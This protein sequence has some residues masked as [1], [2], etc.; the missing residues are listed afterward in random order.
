MKVPV[1]RILHLKIGEI[2][3]LKI[4]ID[5]LGKIVSETVWTIH[6][7]KDK[8]NKFSGLEISTADSSRSIYMK[9]QIE[10]DKFLEFNSKHEKYE[11]GINLEK[12]NKMIKAVE[13][14]DIINMYLSEKD[15]QCLIIDIERAMTKGKKTLK[16]PLI[17]LEQEKK[18]TKK[19]EYEKIVSM[20]ATIYKKIFK[21]F[22][23][24]ENVK[25]KCTKKNILFTYKDDTG[26]EINDEYML[27]EDGINIE[28]F[29]TSDEFTG[30]YPIKYLILFGKCANLCGELQIYMKNKN[31]LVV[32]MPTLSFGTIIISLSPVNEACIANIDYGYSDDEEQI[33][34]IDNYSNKINVSDDDYND[35]YN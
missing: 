3:S 31:A 13:K 15:L 34:V 19:E 1:D 9:I 8:K 22:D 24:F 16:F 25:I 30:V 20:S 27:D 32:K 35:D 23:D 6:N 12:L 2:N 28:I 7:P 5:T 21:E 4:I 29:S 33:T 17:E 26:T 14:D 11:I 10:D 18:P